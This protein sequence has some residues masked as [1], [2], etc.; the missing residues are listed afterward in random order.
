MV[1]STN[2]NRGVVAVRRAVMFAA[3]G[4][5]GFSATVAYAGG[6][7]TGRVTFKGT[8]PATPP[9]MKVEVNADKCGT[10]QAG[11]AAV[12]PDGSIPWAVV[13]IVGAKGEFASSA[14][15][16]TLDQRGC[17]FT[18]HVVVVPVGQPLKV[19][20]N[21]GI[22]HNVHTFPEKNA[23]LNVAQ[24]GFRKTM[25]ATF[26]SPE[27]V[28]VGCDVH[29]WMSAQIVVTDTP[30]IAVTDEKGAFSIAGVPPGTYTVSIWHETFG[31]QTQQ[32]AIADGK[33]SALTVQMTAKVGS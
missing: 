4:L 24:P 8:P 30:F 23:P 15:P 25:D 18:P 16:P 17:R 31:E 7:V 12:A 10:E 20:N 28:R 9:A 6:T 22:L 26:T 29:P 5:L 3:A 13:R 27:V 1:D 14:T 2:V 21:D 19:L 32:V 33:S 11:H